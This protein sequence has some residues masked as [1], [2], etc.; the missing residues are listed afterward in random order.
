MSEQENV[1]LVQKV[2]ENFKSGDISSAQ[3]AFR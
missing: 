3:S 1:S 2:Y